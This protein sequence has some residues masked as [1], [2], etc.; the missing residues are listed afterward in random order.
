MVLTLVFILQCECI[1]GSPVYLFAL[2][3]PRFLDFSFRQQRRYTGWGL[4]EPVL[5]RAFAASSCERSKSIFCCA[6]VK[7]ENMLE[8]TGPGCSTTSFEP[9]ALQK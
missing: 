1:H 2:L 8:A 7:S 6:S 9:S 4:S 3:A 5:F